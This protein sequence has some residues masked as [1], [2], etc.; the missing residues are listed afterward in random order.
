ME[1]RRVAMRSVRFALGILL[2]VLLIFS[3]TGAFAQKKELTVWGWDFRAQ[4]DIA[5]QVQIFEKRHPDVKVNT[6][7]MSADD[8]ANKF[9]MATLAGT[10][11]PDI[12]FYSSRRAPKF[13]AMGEKAILPLDSAIPDYKQQFVDLIIPE[14]TYNGKLW[15]APFD[16]GPFVTFY[17]KDIFDKAGVKYPSNWQEFI[18]VGKKITTRDRLMMPII[19]DNSGFF[20][21]SFLQSMGGQF[22]D[23]KGNPQFNNPTNIE[24]LKYLKDLVSK[25]RI[26]EYA[27]VFDAAAWQKIKDGRWATITIWYWYQSFGLKDLAYTKELDGKWR[28]AEI[29]PWKPG[30]PRTGAN[31]IDSGI[32]LVSS[33]TK[34]PDLAK[35]F[36]A[37]LASK[38]GQLNQAIDRGIFPCNR[39]ALEVLAQR[40]DP[41]FGN[42]SGYAIGLNSLKFAPQMTLG[43]Q[44]DILGSALSTAMDKIFLENADIEK[45]LEDATNQAQ[46]ELAQ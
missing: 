20:D 10:G 16:T 19:S 42:Q 3:T 40:K 13:Y 41:F 8:V 35:E 18:E 30:G 34:Y 32:W 37:L 26:A 38:E 11:A 33:Q 12:T 2:V 14:I 44:R 23:E 22:T 29:L 31:Y 17:R 36:A 25:Y 24:V 6:L 21:I 28:V 5:P 15:A 43:P 1:G 27:K 45:A 9:L 7:N 4:K 46:S 39:L